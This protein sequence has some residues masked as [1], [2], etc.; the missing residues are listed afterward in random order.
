MNLKWLLFYSL[1]LISELFYGQNYN[2]LHWRIEGNALAKPSYLYGTMHSKDSRMHNLGDSVMVSLQSCE[3]VALEI[4]T[5]NMGIRD[6]FGAMKQMYM[7]DTTLKD[8]Y[9]PDTYQLVKKAVSKK[10]GILGVLYNVDKIKPMFLASLLG[11]VDEENDE[12]NRERFLLDMYFQDYGVKNNKSI[13]SIESVEEQ[14]AAID[15]MPLTVQAEMLLEQVNN[16]GKEDSSMDF[17]IQK[18]LEQDLDALF[19]F[20]KNEQ[21]TD[22]DSFDKAIVVNRNNIM[23]ERMDSFMKFMPTFTAVGALHLPGEEGIISLLRKKG[24]TVSPV[25]SSNKVYRAIETKAEPQESEA[26][27]SMYNHPFILLDA[28]EAGFQILVPDSAEIEWMEDDLIMYSYNDTK[29]ELL[30]NIAYTALNDSSVVENET[31]YKEIALRLAK[32]KGAEIEYQELIQ[33]LDFEAQEGQLKMGETLP[34]VYMRYLMVRTSTDFYLLSVTG[35]KTKIM[36][37]EVN[38]FFDSFIILP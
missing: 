30:Y 4:A 25:Y 28:A 3:A 8:L 38:T 5:N 27:L 23:A 9:P 1:I 35:D 26:D 20:Y 12:V 11:E 21:D 17:M 24:Y 16:I 2:T 14:M 7:R 18:Y 32:S 19:S 33:V 22:T 6:F 31:F 36:E 37:P 15:Q 29:N 34:N 13:I 10:M